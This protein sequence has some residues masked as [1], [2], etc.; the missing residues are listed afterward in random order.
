[1]R[2]TQLSTAELERLL[3]ED[4]PYG[5]LTTE[6]LGIGAVPASI[7]FAAR[8]RMVVAAIEDAAGLLELAGIEVN[9]L[10]ASGDDVESGTVLLRG[11]GPAGSIHRGWK[12]AQTLTEIW[13]GVATAARALVLAARSVRSDV[14]VVCTRKNVPGTKAF[15]AAAVKAGGASMRRLGLSETILVLPEHRV[16][17]AKDDLAALLRDLR[18]KAPEKKLIVEVTSTTEACAAAMAGFDVVQAEKFAP[19]RI[20]QLKAAFAGI[21]PRPL[22]AAAGGINPDNA[23]DYVRA[24]ADILVTSFPYTARPADVEVT[25]APSR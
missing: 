17:G 2:T 16:F 7:R 22:L 24:G 18:S 8:Q 20:A 4:V 11:E 5:D 21:T 1:M 14:A 6:V 19:E 25:I 15:A 13:S 10:A 3:A 12:V 23:A 9:L